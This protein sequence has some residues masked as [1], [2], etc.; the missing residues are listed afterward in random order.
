MSLLFVPKA[1]LPC[2][3]KI[4]RSMPLRVLGRNI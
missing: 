3:K 4:R 1:P 2:R